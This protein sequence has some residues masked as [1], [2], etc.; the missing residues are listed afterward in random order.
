MDWIVT[1]LSRLFCITVG[2]IHDIGADSK[3]LWGPELT[4]A[5]LNSSVPME[6]LDDMVT[7][8]LA[9]WFQ[10]GQDRGYPKPNFSAWYKNTTGLVYFSTGEGPQAVMNEHVNVQGNHKDIAR[11]VARDG[12][13]LL[14]NSDNTLPIKAKRGLKIGVYGIDACPTY[15]GP[16]NFPDRGGNNGTLAMAWGSGTAEFPYL[17]DPLEAITAEA[18]RTGA[19]VT[20]ECNENKTAE[21]AA[22]AAKQDICLAFGNADAGE[23]FITLDGN[24]G[25]RNDL[26][27]QRGGAVIPLV[28]KNCKKTVVVIHSVGPVNMESFADHKNVKSILWAHLPGQES[29]NAL[30]DVLFGKVSPSGKLPYTIGKKLDDWGPGAKVIYTRPTET[31]IVQQDFTEGL[32]IDYR[33]FDK[34]NIEPRYEFGFGLSYTTFSLSSLNIRKVGNSSPLPGPLPAKLAPPSFDSKLPPV[35]SAVYPPG[36]RRYPHYVY[37]YI[38]STSNV[39]VGKYPYPA[40][41][42]TKPHKASAAGGGQ[43]GHPDLWKN[44]YEVSVRVKNTGKVYGAEVVQVYLGMNGMRTYGGRGGYGGGNL[45]APKRVLRAFNKVWLHPGESKT[46]TLKLQRRDVSYWDVVQQNWVIP[47]GRMN[48]DVGTSSRKIKLKGNIN[49]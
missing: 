47:S 5:V 20:S 28:A 8:I 38:E 2:L 33:H 24:A 22:S 36:F 49:I 32:Y 48:V 16:N 31:T 6:R 45:D 12:Q 42:S 26:E 30:A 15:G 41:Y 43:G 21:I 46:V 23:G 1:C 35:S 10:L 3:S 40:G 9:S 29:G 19:I 37:P 13:A 17:V 44:V 14:K 7:R 27:L 11:I 34:Y 4:K 18:R 39:T 25:D